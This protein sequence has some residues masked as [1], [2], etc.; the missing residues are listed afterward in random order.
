M[1]KVNR[2]GAS[3][4][5]VQN[6]VRLIEECRDPVMYLHEAARAAEQ[7][8]NDL[9]KWSPRHVKMK[10][11]SLQKL[12]TATRLAIEMATNEENE[13]AALAGELELLELAWEE[14][15]QIAAIADSLAIPDEVEERLKQLREARG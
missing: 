5:Q 15:E 14:A 11:G 7:Q 6:A 12:P 10:A 2:R 3:K 1:P 9:A 13:R 4:G 8:T